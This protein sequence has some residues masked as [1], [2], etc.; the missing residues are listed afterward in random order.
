MHSVTPIDLEYV[1]TMEGKQRVAA[2]INATLA[3]NRRNGLQPQ[4]IRRLAKMAGFRHHTAVGDYAAARIDNPNRNGCEVCRKVAPFIYQVVALRVKGN[5]ADRFIE[6]RHKKPILSSDLSPAAQQV[7]YGDWR[8]F[9]ALGTDE[10][11]SM[12][13]REDAADDLMAQI[14]KR[15]ICSLTPPRLR[16]VSASLGIPVSTIYAMRGHMGSFNKG[17]FATIGQV[18]NDFLIRTT[19]QKPVTFT[20]EQLSAE[21]NPR[22]TG[23]TEDRLR[24]LIEGEGETLLSYEAIRLA[25]IFTA[26]GVPWYAEELEAIAA[27]PVQRSLFQLAED[28]GIYGPSSE[29]NGATNGAM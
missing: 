27:G 10:A 2:A 4:S 25:G 6:V 7:T 29:P 26:Y 23:M 16:S 14:L 17:E 1:W 20:L 28:A 18:I 21:L 5:G 13:W 11:Q 19:D 15:Q 24:Q 9:A 22:I 3:Y 8:E 12:E